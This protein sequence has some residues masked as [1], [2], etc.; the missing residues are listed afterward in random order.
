MTKY[1]ETTYENFFDIPFRTVQ[2]KCKKCHV[3]H[4]FLTD[5]MNIGIGQVWKHQCTIEYCQGDII[6]ISSSEAN[7]K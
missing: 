6:V 7:K 1:T 2:I 3:I 5:N 4:D